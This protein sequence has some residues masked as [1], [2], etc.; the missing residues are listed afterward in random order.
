MLNLLIPGSQHSFINPDL[1]VDILTKYGFTL[2]HPTI[3]NSITLPPI[4]IALS[5]LKPNSL[6]C[7][8]HFI[9]FES[10]SQALEL[11]LSFFIVNLCHSF[12]LEFKSLPSKLAT[13]FSDKVLKLHSVLKLHISP[14]IEFCFFPTNF[15]FF[16][17]AS[18]ENLQ[19]HFSVIQYL[20]SSGSYT[21]FYS[22]TASTC[23]SP[24]HNQHCLLVFE[25]WYFPQNNSSSPLCISLLKKYDLNKEDYLQLQT[26]FLSVILV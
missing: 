14:L 13:F 19:V 9:I 8:T 7:F 11:S 5:L 15:T 21:Y 6:Q 12:H 23:T 16:S 1:L 25:V 18:R 4:D 17:P 3:S 20:L 22:K 26:Y 2:V 24:H 10:S